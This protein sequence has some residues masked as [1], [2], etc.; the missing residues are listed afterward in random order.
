H[1]MIIDYEQQKKVGDCISYKALLNKIKKNFPELESLR[2]F[3]GNKKILNSTKGQDIIREYL[4]YMG[5]ILKNLLFTYNPRK[6]I[7]C[8]EISNYEEFL[9]QDILDIVYEEN[10]N[11]YRGRE[12]IQFSKF[13]GD[14]SII[15]AAIF[16][17]VDK[18]M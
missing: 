12:T 6:L 2:D 10:H 1:H 14:S 16:P 9:L 15:G 7:I 5:V 17:I 4:R 11:F 8:G 13:K 3:F 18:L